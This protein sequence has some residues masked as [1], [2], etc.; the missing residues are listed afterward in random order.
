M[1]VLFHPSKNVMHWGFTDTQ[2]RKISLNPPFFSKG[3]NFRFDP[4]VTTTRQLYP[5]NN[6][7]TRGYCCWYSTLNL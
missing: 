2:T 7:L 6:F 3:K 5:E 4:M 1:K